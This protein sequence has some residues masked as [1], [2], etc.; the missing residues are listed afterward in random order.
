MT[1][2]RLKIPPVAVALL[3]GAGMW[4]LA[5]ATPQFRVDL[6]ARALFAAA[7]G[8]LGIVVIALGVVSFRRAKTTVNPMHPEQASTLVTAGIYGV[9]RNP[10]YL[11]LLLL[12]IAWATVLAHLPAALG[13]AAFV[14][15]MNRFQIRPE[16]V[17]LAEHFGAPYHAYRRTVR[18]WL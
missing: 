2:F 13:A 1:T 10:M 5:R 15:Y 3:A 9:T 4:L 6:P 17:A 11:G 16:E 14:A 18:R 7:L 12:L 8:G